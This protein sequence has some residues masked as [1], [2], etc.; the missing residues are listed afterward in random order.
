M[1]LV[2]QCSNGT[3]AISLCP[4]KESVD[5]LSLEQLP[6]ERDILRRIEKLNHA[7]ARCKKLYRCLTQDHPAGS[8]WRRGNGHLVGMKNVA[9]CPHIEFKEEREVRPFDTG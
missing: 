3:Q 6:K 8:G 4:L 5:N 2:S 7:V 1:V 9:D